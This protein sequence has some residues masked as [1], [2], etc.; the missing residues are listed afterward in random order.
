M[1]SPQTHTYTHTHAHTHIHTHALHTINCPVIKQLVSIMV[2]SGLHVLHSN[3]CLVDSSFQISIHYS[4]ASISFIA[5]KSIPIIQYLLSRCSN[6]VDYEIYAPPIW[7][8]YSQHDT[9][10]S[11]QW[12]HVSV[13]RAS[14]NVHYMYACIHCDWPFLCSCW[15]LVLIQWN[16]KQSVRNK[17]AY[18]LNVHT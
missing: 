1:T 12:M 18:L 11:S 4:H 10:I 6:P 2:C 13:R 15:T 8:P 16:L 3:K 5:F 17:A 14:Q 7:L 9:T